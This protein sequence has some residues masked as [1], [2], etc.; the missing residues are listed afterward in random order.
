MRRAATLLVVAVALGL[1]LPGASIGATPLISVDSVSVSPEQPV[2]GET[3][4]I[5]PTVKNLQGSDGVFEINGILLKDGSTQYTRITDMGA[6]LSAGSSTEIPLTATF[7]ST[8]TKRLTIEVWGQLEGEKGS[9]NLRYPVTVEVGDNHPSVSV[10]AS[11]SAAGAETD[12]SVTIAN[13]LNS[14]VENVEVSIAGDGVAVAGGQTVYA[15]IDSGATETVA[16]TVTH[17]SAG[18]HTVN[19]TIEYMTAGGTTRT[20]HEE[21]TVTTTTADSGDDPQASFTASDSVVGVD[22]TSTV[23]IANGLDEQMRN[24]E[25]SVSGANVTVPEDRQVY[26]TLASGSQTNSTFTYRPET[27]GT[28]ELTAV[29]NYTTEDG[30]SRTVRRTATAEASSFDGNVSLTTT[31]ESVGGTTRLTVA[32]LNRENT[33]IDDVTISASS[34]NATAGK[35][36][37][38]SVP[39]GEKRSATL[40]LTDFSGDAAVTVDA[41]FAVGDRSQSAST[42]TTVT[43]RTTTVTLTGIDI[44]RENDGRLHIT[45]TASNLG[46]REAKSVVVS[47]VDAEGV[48]PAHPNKEFFVG[49]VPASDFVSF[50]LYANVDEGTETVPVTLEYLVDGSRH[51]HTERIEVGDRTG[52]EQRVSK[53]G[54]FGSGLLLP[55]GLGTVVVLAVVA[56][57]VTAWRRSRGGD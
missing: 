13:G 52:P 6:T 5:T 54:G 11:D 47:V 3:V 21:T 42:T 20:T 38:D 40:N 17:Q 19:A 30:A 39:A 45:G 48:S 34:P 27:T 8:G 32:V 23:I 4:T 2:P 10:T 7:E 9:E 57:I 25:V 31:S 44:N 41:D 16:Y 35:A 55:A 24:V 26:A 49:S 28:N 50:D 22:A 51:E 33:A 29:I 18:T 56:I 15:S 37:I 36:V 12:G 1:A 43:S 46:T 14:K 53:A